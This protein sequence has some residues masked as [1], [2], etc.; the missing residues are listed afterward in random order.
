MPGVERPGCEAKYHLPL[1][2]EVKNDGVIHQIPQFIYAGCI[3]T[4]L[5]LTTPNLLETAPGR[6]SLITQRL[7]VRAEGGFSKVDCLHC[8]VPLV[9]GKMNLLGSSAAIVVRTVSPASVAWKESLDGS[10]APMVACTVSRASVS[11]KDKPQRFVCCHGCLQCITCL[12]RKKGEPQRFFC[13]HG[14]LHCVSYS[15]FK[16][17]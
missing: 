6:G 8:L 2:A 3:G 9:E 10:S 4:A 11:R 13:S 1:S 15:C 7:V 16:G 12:C 17:R 5:P 14:C